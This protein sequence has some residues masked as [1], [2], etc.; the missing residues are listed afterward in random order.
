MLSSTCEQPY[1]TPAGVHGSICDKFAEY[2]KF[3]LVMLKDFTKHA[4][5]TL[6]IKT[7]SIARTRNKVVAAMV[8]CT[9]EC[10]CV[11]GNYT[12]CTGFSTS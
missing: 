11:L 6:P 7:S 10:I 9:L 12:Y 3:W 5:R 1:F 8:V 2:C 4:D